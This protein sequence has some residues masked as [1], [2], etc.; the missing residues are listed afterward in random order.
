MSVETTAPVTESATPA[1]ATAAADP[2]PAPAE[3]AAPAADDAEEFLADAPNS[4]AEPSTE[5][6]AD[7]V[8]PEEKAKAD[9]PDFL[10]ETDDDDAESEGDGQADPKQESE[11]EAYQQFT[12]PEG[13]ELDEA[14]LTEVTPIFRE[15]N[16]DQDGAQ[17]LVSFYASKTQDALTAYHQKL[18]E[19]HQETL[20]TW[21]NELRELP[22]YKG[23][24]AFNQAKGRV[25]HVLNTLG[26]PE[27]KT[28][29]DKDYGLIRNKAV[30]TFLDAVASKLS[31]DSLV[32]DDAG[33]PVKEP[34]KRAADVMYS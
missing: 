5:G 10:A 29:L 18:A 11:P 7:D 12:L 26:S 4:K 22:D 31:E 33:A 9:D 32:R 3:G 28:L 19:G 15:L 23:K 17:K 13:V 30:F 21:S 6:K 24:D 25:A 14:T 16:L 8:K 34:P 2:S 27:L 20:R 1:P